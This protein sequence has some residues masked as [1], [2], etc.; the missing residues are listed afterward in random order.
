M[1][2]IGI[3]EGITMEQAL[4]RLK[5]QAIHPCVRILELLAAKDAALRP[6]I[7][8]I[9]KVYVTWHFCELRCRMKEAYDAEAAPDLGLASK[10][11]CEYLDLTFSVGWVPLEEWSLSEGHRRRRL[12][13]SGKGTQVYKISANN[14]IH[15]FN[16]G[17]K[18]ATSVQI[19]EERRRHLTVQSV[20]LRL[21]ELQYSLGLRILN[22]SSVRTTL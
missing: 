12:Y 8:G 2:K 10:R 16:C 20:M 3:F 11:I 4:E 5:Y 15:R 18:E 14:H 1:S 6:P 7:S 22:F 19:R 13:F 9:I 17:E 21:I